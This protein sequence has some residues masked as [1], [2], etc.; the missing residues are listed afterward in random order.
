MSDAGGLKSW[1]TTTDHKRIGLLYF[2]TALG[3]FLVGGIEALFIRVQLA[4]PNGR[5]VSAETYNQLFTMH[6]TTMI[7]LALMPLGASFFNYMVPLQIGARD[8]AFPRLNAFSYWV[9]LFGGLFLNASWFVGPLFHAGMLNVA[10]NGGWFGYANLTER[11]YSA[12]PNIDFWML[13]LQVLG[14]SSLA[15]GFNFIVTILNMRAPGMRMMRLPVF[16]WMTL[17]TQFLIVTA[18][19]VIT[20]GLAFLMFD[21]FFGTH[22]YVREAGATPILWQHLFWLFGHPEVYI[23]ILPAMGVVSDVLP[24]FSRKPLFGYTVVVY[25]GVLIGLMSWGVWSHHM[26]AVGLGPIADSVFAGTTMLIAIPTGVKIFNWLGTLWGGDIRGTTALHF[27]V[28]FIAMFIIGGL[29]GVS[30]ASPPADLQ[31][32]D[33]YYVVAH[34]HY[35]FFGG[36]ILG[37][38]AGIYYWWP[39]MT[40]RLLNE[41][42]GKW[43][44]WLQLVGMNLAF[45]PMHFIGL[46][47]MPRRVYTYSPEL[48]VGALNLVSTIGAF[49]IALAILIFLVN[50]WHSRTHGQPAPNDPW[51]GA[52]LEWSVSSPPPVY[53]FSVIPT[54]TSRLPRWSTERHGPMRDPPAMPPGPIHVPGGSWWPLVAALGLPVMALALLTHTLWVAFV[55]VA[56]LIGGIYRWAFEPLEV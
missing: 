50:L 40:G 18:F 5:V 15:A 35:V 7:F 25:S 4:Q 49:L 53:N 38:F 27:A 44:F 19:P 42:L 2:W 56:L 26:F 20:V 22:F 10:P 30:H 47:G 29:S 34:I 3:F 39:K 32:T 16:T 24:T 52:T 1:L 36:T 51:G 37:L 13:G 28:G 55:G 43:H 12:G 17:V 6:G 41:S 8:V 11:Q 21:R 9:F 46:L 54:V 31:Q 45:F 14:I 23:L 33:T 48:G